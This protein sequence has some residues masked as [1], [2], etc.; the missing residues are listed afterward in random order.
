MSFLPL[1]QRHNGN[2]MNF[3]G[4]SSILAP[5]WLFTSLTRQYVYV[6]SFVPRSA[7]QRINSIIFVKANPSS[8]YFS[9][10]KSWPSLL[11]QRDS[12]APS[13]FHYSEEK[14]KVKR[15]AHNFKE[16]SL[17]DPGNQKSHE[18]KWYMGHPQN[19]WSSF[20]TLQVQGRHPK[21]PGKWGR[22]RTVS[23]MRTNLG[24]APA[25][26]MG[27]DPRVSGSLS[28]KPR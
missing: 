4:R 15:N 11:P 28:S 17:F 24:L 13:L 21:P 25:Q 7:S 18:Y 19:R 1:R 10:T 6:G 14:I 5:P 3:T 20:V 22:T 8:H 26:G 12:V 16:S 2:K 23:G 27:R 9:T